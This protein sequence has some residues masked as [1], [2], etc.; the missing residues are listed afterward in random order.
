MN[1]A[2][3]TSLELL[4]ALGPLLLSDPRWESDMESALLDL[5]GMDE[6]PTEH[7]SELYD[8]I[9][10]AI[11]TYVGGIVPFRSEPWYPQVDVAGISRA[12]DVVAQNAGD[13][14]SDEWFDT[15][16]SMITASSAWKIIG[17]QAN[18]NS[19]VWEKTGPQKTGHT[20]SN[21]E[22]STHWG[23]KY[24]PVAVL[25]Y[26]KHTG[27]RVC[28]VGCVRHDEHKYIG[29]SPDGIIVSLGR[30]L[31][32]KCVV[33]REITG[34]PT[35]AYWTQMQW[36][37]EVMGLDAI[38][39]WEGQFIEYAD[40]EESAADGTFHNTADGKEKGVMHQFHSSEG[41]Y[42][43]YASLDLDASEFDAWTT[44]VIQENDNATWIQ[45]RWWKL[46]SQSCVTVR[47]QPEWFAQVLPVAQELWNI[48]T[49]VRANG[50]A[51][52]YSPCGH[53]RSGNSHT[54]VTVVDTIPLYI[55]SDEE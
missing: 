25:L 36:Q 37:A 16:Q 34:V 53:Q 29:A 31:E 51:D 27:H 28:Q 4:E 40:A 13:Q 43:I 30:G 49:D 10:T 6:I 3:T 11:H 33:S 38:D 18:T 5:L 54:E 46:A 32:I 48:I 19:L 26:E 9:Q 45:T 35:K 41:T 2:V 52:K 24:E 23:E 50:G 55:P 20:S 39:F 7:E 21:I 44:S 14:R 17:S 12:A 8:A 22:S 47:R 15:R 42:Y 1:D